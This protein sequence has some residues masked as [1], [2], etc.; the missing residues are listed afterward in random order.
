[1]Q[2]VCCLLVAL[3]VLGH[4]LGALRDGVL[5]ELTWQQQAHGSLD[6]SAGDRVLVVVAGQAGGLECK[7]L[8]N[9]V[10]E[11]VH[12]RHCA[13]GDTSVGVDLLEHLV[14]VAGVGLDLLE[15][16]LGL[17]ALSAFLLGDGL[18]C[19]LLLCGLLLCGFLLSG[20]LCHG[21]R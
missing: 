1:M 19:R 17:L 13:L 16:A 2:T 20:L 15:M 12:D 18:L 9:V 5:G 21:G 4:S 3:S 6:L 14:D 11:R 10:H 8:E 7:A